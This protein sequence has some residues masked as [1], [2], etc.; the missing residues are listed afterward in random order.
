MHDFNESFVY[1]YF[2]CVNDLE[3]HKGNILFKAK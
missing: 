3:Y 1:D 2:M